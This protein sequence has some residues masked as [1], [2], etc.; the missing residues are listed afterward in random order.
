M[1]RKLRLSAPKLTLNAGD[2]LGDAIHGSTSRAD[3][4]RRYRAKGGRISDAR[5]YGAGKGKKRKG[6]KYGREQVGVYDEAKRL[7]LDRRETFKGRDDPS[8]RGV[9]RE[10]EMEDQ[11]VAAHV[12]AKYE[13]Y[14]MFYV[15]DTTQYVDK[16]GR[17]R[18]RGT[19]I[20]RTFEEELKIPYKQPKPKSGKLKSKPWVERELMRKHLRGMEGIDSFKGSLGG[21][22]PPKI[23]AVRYSKTLR[24]IKRPR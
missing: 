24:N 17:I 4:L 8:W 7:G 14:A 10:H 9:P 13:Q 15:E 16:R 5:W 6:D 1:A 12:G 23:L 19:G 22:E 21:Y 18:Y 11:K 3:A 2:L 20:L